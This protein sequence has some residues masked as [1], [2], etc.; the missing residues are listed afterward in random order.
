[1]NRGKFIV[2]E[3]I[4]G[5]GKSTQV[6]LLRKRL[7]DMGRR[8]ELTAEPTS[9]ESGK[10]IRRALSGEI[11]KS[12]CEMASMFVLDRIAHN[13]CEGGI[14]ATVESGTDLISDRYYYST[15][16]YQGQTTDYEWVKAMNTRCPEIAR[17]DLCI[18][19]DLLPEQSLARIQKRGEAVEIY[20]NA[21]K[22]TSVRRAFLSV[23]DDLRASGE[24]IVVIDAY[25]PVEQIADEIFAAVNKILFDN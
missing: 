1:M 4:D 5:A 15:L 2:F 14:K 7:T 16:A 8:V 20:E 13:V 6:E 12:E 18:Y 23:I 10:A 19:L 11:K 25:R 17:P 22:L 24:K 9:L 3:G 21:E